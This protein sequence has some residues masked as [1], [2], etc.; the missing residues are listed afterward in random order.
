[1]PSSIRNL[2]GL[3]AA[4]LAIALVLV[5]AISTPDQR[6]AGHASAGC[7]DALKAKVSRP[8]QAGA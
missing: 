6:R 8:L 4:A 3:G 5:S 2:A 1:M 7:P